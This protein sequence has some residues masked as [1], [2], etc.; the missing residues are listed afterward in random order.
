[1]SQEMIQ[2]HA[3]TFQ[4]PLKHQ[5]KHAMAS[6]TQ[7]ASVLVKLNDGQHLGLGEGCPRSYVTG[8][9]L[10]SCLAQLYSWRDAI[11]AIETLD[12]A[13]IA[14]LGQALNPAQAHNAAWCALEGALLDLHAKRLNQSVE[15]ALGLPTEPRTLRYSA[16]LPDASLETLRA[17][18]SRFLMLGMTDIKLRADQD[19]EVLA[20]KIAM[21]EQLALEQPAASAQPL[22]LRVECNN[23]W[24]KD[25]DAAHRALS[26]IAH[27]LCAI[28]EPLAAGQLDALSALSQSLKLPII[29]D[30]TL[31]A[32]KAPDALRALP[33][34]WI[35][36]IKVSK[37]GGLQR[38]IALIQQLH[39]QGTPVILGAH[40]G[41][42]SILTRAATCAARATAQ[43]FAIEGAFGEHLLTQDAVSPSLSFGRGGLLTTEP[44][45][46]D[47]R[48]WG[49]TLTA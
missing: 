4:L 30:E 5:A 47:T 14:Q 49:L 6:F 42:T 15:A 2:L 33:G 45:R 9:S 10:E 39:A 16:V 21:I 17:L 19:P 8:E 41:E 18:A 43:L 27:K 26:P 11:E 13:A 7:S 28:E 37:L 44:E 22:R 25:P 48:G 3:Q 24:A 1:M 31:L 34:Q 12:L 35:A 38:T 32:L 20:A 29:L 46:Q 36:N 40:I 23:L